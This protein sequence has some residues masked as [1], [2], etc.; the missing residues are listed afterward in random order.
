VNSPREFARERFLE[1]WAEQSGELMIY[2]RE[3][4]GIRALAVILVVLFHAGFDFISGGFVGVDVFFVISGFLISRNIIEKREKFSFKEFYVRRVR[5]LFPAAFA[6]IIV[7]TIVAWFVMTGPDFRAVVESAI[8]AVPSGS[9][10]LFWLQSGYWDAEALSKP[11]LHT[12]SLAVEEQFYLVWPALIVGIASFTQRSKYVFLFLALTLFGMATAEWAA[13]TIPSAAFYLMPFRVAEFAI[14]G[15]YAAVELRYGITKP[16]MPAWLQQALM[17]IGFT[18]ILYAATQFSED[19]VFPGLSAMVPCLGTVIL[20]AVGRAGILGHILSNPVSEYLGKISYSIY[21]T[22]WPILSLYNYLILEEMSSLDRFGLIFAAL[23][24]AVALFHL[25]EQP[26]RRPRSAKAL[27][28][29]GVAIVG[30]SAAYLVTVVAF[31]VTPQMSIAT[32]ATAR[33]PMMDFQSGNETRYLERTRVCPTGCL[34]PSTDRRNI[35]VLGDSH[36]TDGW[37]AMRAAFPN[38]HV[39]IAAVPGCKVY[40]DMRAV[41]AATRMSEADQRRC[42]DTAASVFENPHLLDSLD[43]VVFSFHTTLSDLRYMQQTIEF[44][45]RSTSG[46]ILVMGNSP[47]FLRRIPDVIRERS[48]DHMATIPGELVDER[49]RLDEEMGQLAR[50]EGVLFISKWDFLCP[51]GECLA[52]QDEEPLTYDTHHMSRSAALAFGGLEVQQMFE[53]LE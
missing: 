17:I 6:T 27:Q 40:F 19:T 43:I 38:D 7:T 28:S 10:I 51:T 42:L 46:Q 25:I 33:I 36:G 37:N 35:L 47:V 14:G 29:G 21:L 23:V 34:E 11:L 4:D 48:L 15:L 26:L 5:R 45:K 1:P 16:T 22:H 18:L 2:R 12:W 20:I 31:F 30:L 24:A 50:S 39:M 41:L 13:Q 49:W 3:L 9:N 53:T 52:Y 8:A 44:L 32:I